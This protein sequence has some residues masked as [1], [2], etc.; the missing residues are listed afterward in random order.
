MARGRSRIVLRISETPSGRISTK[1]KKNKAENPCKKAWE[2]LDGCRLDTGGYI[3]VSTYQNNGRY[4]LQS[5]TEHGEPECPITVNLDQ[6]QI[7]QNEFFVKLEV[8]EI[9]PEIF[10]ELAAKGVAHPTDQVVSAGWVERYARVWRL[11]IDTPPEV[12]RDQPDP[13]EHG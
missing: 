4:S 6:Y 7:Y 3:R 12:A 8:E 9:C 2:A 1:M 10:A 11:V 5:F 13:V